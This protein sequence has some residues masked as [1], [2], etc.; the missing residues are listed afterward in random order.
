MG[1]LRATPFLASTLLLLIA[2]A[3][4]AQVHAASQTFNFSKTETFGNVTVT[5]NASI[6]IDTT[7]KTI[8]GTVTVTAV[9]DTSGQ[10][11]F[12]KMFN[13]N[14]SYA[15]SM[16]TSSASFILMIPSIGQVLAASCSVNTSTNA[17]SC[18]VSKTPDVNHDGVVN[19]LDLASVASH[20][21]T[22]DPTYDINNRG[23]VDVTDLATAALYYNAPIV[24]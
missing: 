9:N 18:T 4:L 15:T 19:V 23:V 14:V 13:I 17:S 7:A 3:P 16:N 10:T 5:I 22:S 21:G 2:F 12:S 1:M 6:T 8:T 20:Y 11:I 24:W